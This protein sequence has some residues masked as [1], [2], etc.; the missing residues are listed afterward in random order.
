M[1]FWA[2]GAIVG[3]SIISGAI[4]ADASQSA[5]N[6]QAGA[7][8]QATQAQLGMFNQTQQNLA[9]WMTAGKGSLAQLQ[10]LV[11]SG[12][13]QLGKPFGMADFMADPGYQW[14]V[15]Q[16]QD[17]I[18]NQRSALGGVNSGATLKALSDYT[19]GQ[20]TGTWDD[21]YG[22]YIQQN[23]NL[24]N[25][26]NSMS[27]TGANAAAGLGGI[28]TQVGEQI[29]SN[30]MGAGNA[31]AAGQIGSANAITGA[32]GQGFNAYLMSQ[33]LNP[34]GGN[35]YGPWGGP[36]PQTVSPA[37]FMDNSMAAA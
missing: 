21:A 10:G 14:R 5:A 35:P 24:F 34:G 36:G 1:T 3:G 25:M 11:G 13:G 22:R 31:R 37:S 12:P 26:L 30:I 17:A 15:Q 33:Y 23:Q 19:A 4:G 7:A 18:M 8:N 16:G 29:G 28:G 6:T 32:M 27:G 2:A 20:A 9:P